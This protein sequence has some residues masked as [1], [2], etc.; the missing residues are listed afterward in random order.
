M[1]RD[2]GNIKW[3][4][5]MLPDHIVELIKW[6]DKDR[7]EERTELSEWDLRS[8]QEEIETSYK[9]KY[10]ALIK[11]WKDG[12]VKTRGGT[13]KLLDLRTECIVL[14]N[15]FGPERIPVLDIIGVQCE[16]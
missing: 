3:T 10:E 4:A 11:T 2:R 16:E 5:M 14:D 6:M 8:I 7:Y 15:P 9:R 12:K 13:I 1:I